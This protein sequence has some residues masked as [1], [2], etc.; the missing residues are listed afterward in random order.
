MEF[1]IIKSPSEGTIDIIMRRIG[2]GITKKMDC[3][4]A[5]GLV[6]GRMIEM[7]FAADIAEKAVGVTVADV[8]GSCPQNMILIAIFGDT[9]S[10]EAAMHE[11]KR[12][13]EEGICK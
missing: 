1:R 6:Q 3:I 13:S 10:V 11:I 5:V 4:D 7:I 8:R 2:T 9:S 12:K